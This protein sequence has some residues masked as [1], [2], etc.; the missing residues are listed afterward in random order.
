MYLLIEKTNGVFNGFKKIRENSF[1][2][3]PNFTSF[4]DSCSN[5]TGGRFILSGFFMM[6]HFEDIKNQRTEWEKDIQRTSGVK[7]SLTV[8]PIEWLEKNWANWE[9]V[10]PESDLK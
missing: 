3:I 6:R 4:K 5:L 2:V 9:R 10:F 7:L 8:V 1:E